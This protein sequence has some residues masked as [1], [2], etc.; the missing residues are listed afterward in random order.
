MKR[1]VV[2]RRGHVEP[3]TPVGVQ[4]YIAKCEDDCLGPVDLAVY[5][6]CVA[7]QA[8]VSLRDPNNLEGGYCTGSPMRPNRSLGGW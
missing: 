5:R 8:D 4:T 3:C 2:I 6:E 7:H 1:G